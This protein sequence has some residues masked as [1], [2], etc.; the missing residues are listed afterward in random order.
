[1]RLKL[2]FV[3][4]IAALS[5]CGGLE[6]IPKLT[7]PREDLLTAYR[8]MAEGDQMFVDGRE[9]F[10]LLKY[11]EASRLNPYHEVIFNRLAMAF[12][13]VRQFR[14]ADEA[15]KRA[16]RLEPEY[17]FAHNTRGIIYLATRYNRQAIRSFK[18]AIRLKPEEASF[19]LN[20]GHAYVRDDEYQE[21]MRTY[22]MAL[23][24]DPEIFQRTDVIELSY[25]FADA[26]NPERFY[27]MARIFA[28]LGDKDT[29]LEYLG[30]ALS[31]GFSDSRRLMSEAAF[32]KLRQDA[33]FIK[34]IASYGI[35]E[36]TS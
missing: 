23:Q 16:I 2:L 14:Q 24:I 4:T 36:S 9:H 29:C 25:E 28:E 27:Q 31:A 17:P 22:Q 13:R 7:V 12:S 5:A 30:K 34:L 20:L 10:A 21:G 1:M 3:L 19:Y 33:E 11:L 15:V 8:L 32:E 35:A 6:R 18:E 26:A